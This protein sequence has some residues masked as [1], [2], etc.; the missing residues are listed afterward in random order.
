MD[1]PVHKPALRAA[2]KIQPPPPRSPRHTSPIQPVKRQRLSE[3]QPSVAKTETPVQNT[4]PSAELIQ[5]KMEPY[6]QGQSNQSLNDDNNADDNFVDDPLEDTNADDGNEDYSMMEGGDEEPQA[7]T[8]TDVASGEGQG[9]F[10]LY[11]F[12]GRG[13]FLYGLAGYN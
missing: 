6:D 9:M 5:F 1:L 12:I 7:G 3:P 4:A 13:G 8:S 11:F 2:K 10:I